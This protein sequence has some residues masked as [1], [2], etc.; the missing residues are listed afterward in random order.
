[1]TTTRDEAYKMIKSD[2]IEIFEIDEA[3]IKP[4]ATLMDDLGLD[5]IDGVDMMVRMQERTGKKVTPDQF[6]NVRTINDLVDL[7]QTLNS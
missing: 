2:L 1:M 7:V 6:E 5:S 3:D 4:D